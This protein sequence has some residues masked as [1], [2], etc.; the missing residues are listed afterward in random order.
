MTDE[1]IYNDSWGASCIFSIVFLLCLECVEFFLKPNCLLWVLQYQRFASILRSPTC[2]AGKQWRNQGR[3]PRVLGLFGQIS[4]LENLTPKCKRLNV[5]WIW[6]ESIVER[7]LKKLGNLLFSLILNLGK[8]ILS[9][10]SKNEQNL[11]RMAF[12]S[13]FFH[14][15]SQSSSIGWGVRPKPPSRP[16]A[17]VPSSDPR[18]DHV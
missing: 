4:H 2:L 12:K 8:V 14:E 16:A 6:P 11:I 15:N 18:R 9:N 7:E 17:E 3:N 1:G 10:G 13:F 5:F